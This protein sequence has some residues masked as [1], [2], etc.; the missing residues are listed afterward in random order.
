MI[1]KKKSRDNYYKNQPTLLRHYYKTGASGEFLST[2][3]ENYLKI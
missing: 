1:T 2:L 3:L